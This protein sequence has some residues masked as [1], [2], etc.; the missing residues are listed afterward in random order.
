MDAATGVQPEPGMPVPSRHRFAHWTARR[1]YTTGEEIAHVATH[2]VGAVL[3]GAGLALLCVFA[4]LRGNAWHVVS[5][6]VYGATLV[7][8]YSASCVYHGVRGDK[9]KRVTQIIDHAGIY[10]LIAGTYTPFTLVTLHGPYGWALFGT[11]WGLA[12]VGVAVEAFWVD[13]PGWL[14]A[15]VF[16][17]MGWLVVV[18]AGP[19]MAG[20]GPGGTRLLVAGGLAYSGGTIFYVLKKVPYAHAV[21]HV[22]VVAGSVC[23]FLA[24]LFYV[25]PGR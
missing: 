24:V 2:A 5:V 13:R 20:L 18:A 19:L 7:M 21:W 8:L 22:F 9:A 4:A 11:V 25:L 16:L 17:C 23:H 14:L 15:A 10:L 12:V 6:A 1:P 3:G